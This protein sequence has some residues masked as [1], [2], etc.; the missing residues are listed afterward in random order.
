[1]VVKEICG[2]V[3]FNPRQ[4]RREESRSVLSR[5]SYLAYELA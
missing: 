2:H 3:D 5:L 4:P 1:M